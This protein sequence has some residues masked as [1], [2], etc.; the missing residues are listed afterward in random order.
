MGSSFS[1][2]SCR[3]TERSI[4][5]YS[6]HEQHVLDFR[7]RHRK[8]WNSWEVSIDG[9]IVV[10]RAHDFTEKA[11]LRFGDGSQEYPPSIEATMTGME[12]LKSLRLRI[13]RRVLYDE[14]E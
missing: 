6:T 13:D 11:E 7:R 9:Q 1:Q 5:V 12:R 14:T 8:L 3:W 2:D 10:K 4:R